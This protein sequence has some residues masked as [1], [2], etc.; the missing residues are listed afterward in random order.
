MAD[1]RQSNSGKGDKRPAPDL[2]MSPRAWLVW[3][4]IMALITVL[5]KVGG[6][7]ETKYRKID[8]KQFV[9]LVDSNLIANGVIS[10]NPQSENL[11]EVTGKFWERTGAGERTEVPF[12]LEIRRKLHRKLPGQLR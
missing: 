12:R 4:G 11:R 8:Y 1:D 7:F 10:Y 2:R 9:S 6:S 5:W 3:I